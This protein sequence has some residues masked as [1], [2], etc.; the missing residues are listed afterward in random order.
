ML[1]LDVAAVLKIAATF[2]KSG[3]TVEGDHL[4]FRAAGNNSVNP[5]LRLR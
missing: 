1:T 5:L 4:T 2:V 3:L